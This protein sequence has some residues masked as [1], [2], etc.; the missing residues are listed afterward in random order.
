MRLFL[1]FKLFDLEKKIWMKKW[2]SYPK[3]KTKNKMESQVKWNKSWAFVKIQWDTRNVFT[4]MVF[5]KETK[6]RRKKHIY[7]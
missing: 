4:K 1:L 2:Q 3:S 7:Q 6:K 5:Y